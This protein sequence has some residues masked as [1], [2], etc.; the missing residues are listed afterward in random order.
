MYGDYDKTQMNEFVNFYRKTDVL[1]YNNSKAHQRDRLEQAQQL[2][3]G[4]KPVLRNFISLV[5]LR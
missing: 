4:N 2:D 5:N 3:D 1:G